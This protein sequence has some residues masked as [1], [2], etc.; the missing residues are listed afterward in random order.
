MGTEDIR[1][2]MQY[3]DQSLDQR[4]R[5]VQESM[6]ALGR[7]VEKIFDKLDMLREQ[8]ISVEKDSGYITDRIVETEASFEKF[9]E[10]CDDKMRESANNTV[11]KS[12][13]KTLVVILSTACGALATVVGYFLIQAIE[14]IK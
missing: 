7:N 3:I 11:E 6:S 2:L 12:H 14:K 5:P 10:H 4:L 1:E 9:K 13:N 8:V